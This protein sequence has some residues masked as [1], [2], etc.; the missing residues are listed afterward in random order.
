MTGTLEIT[1]VKIL[2]RH[3]GVLLKA[4]I[5]M[6][7]LKLQ[8]KTDAMFFSCLWNEARLDS[9]APASSLI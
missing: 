6:L 5:E 7:R 2:R 8:F 1:E 4:T 3:W 9:L